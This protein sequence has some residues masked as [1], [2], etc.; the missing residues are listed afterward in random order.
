MKYMEEKYQRL[1]KIAE[2]ELSCSAHNMEH[3]IRVYYLSLYLAKDEADVDLDVIKTAAL[4]HD[5]ARV[6]EDE[7]N[8]GN[9]DHAVLGAEMTEEI[10]KDLDYSQ[11]KIEQIKHCIISHRF[12]SGNEPKTKEAK[13]LFDADKLDVIG[14]IG[15]ARSFIIAGQYGERMYSDVPIDEYIEE[16]LVGGKPDGRIRDISKHAPNIEFETKFKHVPDRLYT[17]KAKEIA[18]RKMEYMKQFFETLRRELKGE[19]L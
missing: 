3:V 18:K 15:I 16:N 2:K 14:A 10:L 1:K 11:Q 12:R 5:I 4:L 7:D 17:P 8:S 9:I 19:I 6:K 13:I